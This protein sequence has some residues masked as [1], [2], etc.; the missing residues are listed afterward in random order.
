[1]KWENG[2]GEGVKRER[3]REK[4]T[5]KNSFQYRVDRYNFIFF[6]SRYFGSWRSMEKSGEWFLGN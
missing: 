4:K 5:F 1:M 6:F 3:E 2:E